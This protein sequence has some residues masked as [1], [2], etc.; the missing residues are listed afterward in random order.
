MERGQ[1]VG[2]GKGH[3]ISPAS[4]EACT[5]TWRC[6]GKEGGR[7]R[8]RMERSKTNT[9]GGLPHQHSQ[10]AG[11]GGGAGGGGGGKEGVSQGG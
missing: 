10:G 9:K 11:V 7:G 6:R 3:P 2:K 1:M 8:G 4:R 5:P